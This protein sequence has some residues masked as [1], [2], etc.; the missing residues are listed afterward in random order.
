M[1]ISKMSLHNFRS[2]R[3]DHELVFNKGVNF[4]LGIITAENHL[5]Y[6]PLISYAQKGQEMKS[7]P[8]LQHRTNLF[9]LKSNLAVTILIHCS[10]MMI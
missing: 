2:F 7:S 1:Y 6:R 4:L 10:I 9:Q 5:Y 8:K 3:G